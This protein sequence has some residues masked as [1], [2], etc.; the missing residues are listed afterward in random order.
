MLFFPHKPRLVAQK[1]EPLSGISPARVLLSPRFIA[2]AAALFAIPLSGLHAQPAER[3]TQVSPV[4][5]RLIADV[6]EARSSASVS[7]ALSEIRANWSPALIPQLLEATR[8]A[9]TNEAKLQVFE[10]LRTKTNQRF[11]PDFLKWYQWLWRQPE[12]ITSDYSLFKASLYQGIDP[13]F[14][15]YFEGQQGTAKIRLDEI[16]WGGVRQD[17]IPPLRQPEMISAAE[18]RYLSD[19][20]IVFGIEINGDARAYPKRILAWH[21]MFID[22]I[23]GVEI[24][25]VYCT[26]CGMVIP[27]RT[28]VADQS[29]AFGTSGFLYR[30]NK[31][32]YDQ[33]THSLWNSMQGTPVLGP[34]A[35]SDIKL[36]R[37]AVVTTTWG[38]WRKRHPDTT[39]LSLNTGHS[40]DYSEGEAYRDYFATDELLF[41]TPFD[42]D[43]LDNKREV[44]ALRFTGGEL[45]IDSQFL[46]KNPIYHDRVGLQDFVVVT[47]RTGAARVYERGEIDFASYD[48]QSTLRDAQEREWALNE[49]Q[50]TSQDGQSLS[51]LPSHRAFWFGWYA[52]FP[53]TRLVK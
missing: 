53:A 34:L 20:N 16:I 26:L 39:V 45:A 6:I 13:A 46:R 8:F 50:L 1:Y 3:E 23:G 15:R 47:D 28:Q 7:Q 10:L 25:G 14:A 12:R 36:E 42:D 22:T 48:G 43:R 5:L 9:R 30:S 19:N 18:A 49:N 29:F 17:G 24:A 27:Y 32:M 52:S 21:E 2:L 4:E 31:L 11:G 44:V 40:R 33:A 41:N 51:R 38:E 37:E 35:K